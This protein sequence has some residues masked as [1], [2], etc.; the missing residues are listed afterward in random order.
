MTS[1]TPS[2][3]VIG[4]PNP[5]GSGLSVAIARNK[6]HTLVLSGYSVPPVYDENDQIV[7]GW[8]ERFAVQAMVGATS[9]VTVADF[10]TEADAVDYITDD[11]DGYI[12]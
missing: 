11:P 8:I 3:R 1:P 10:A 6:I 4:A 5:N 12:A 7:T 9:V 2:P